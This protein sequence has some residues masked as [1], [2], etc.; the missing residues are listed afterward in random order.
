MSTWTSNSKSLPALALALLIAF[1]PALAEAKMGGGASSGSRGSRTSTPPAA[2]TT[3]PRP[4]APMERSVAPQPAP[5]PQ[6]SPAAPQRPAA[7]PAASPLGG[8]FGRGLL[9]GLAGGLLGAG[10]FGL[11][12]GNGL[13]GG[14]GGLASIIGLLVQIAII[15]LLARLAFQWFANRRLAGAMGGAGGGSRPGAF[16]FT[17]GG[18]GFGSGTAPRHP[19]SE[20]LNLR[21]EDF[22]AFERVLGDAQAAYSQEDIGRLHDLAMPEMVSY[23]SDDIRANAREGVINRISEVKLLQGDLSEAWREGSDEY[24]TVAMR[25]SLIDLFIDR[26]TGKIVSGDAAQPTQSTEVWTFRRPA[27]EAPQA[28]KLSAIQ[29]AA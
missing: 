5:Q 27:G 16:A 21:P 3:A 12:S 17:G 23:F 2:T 24:A 28:W 22:S 20:P 14:L 7:A 13:M 26:A 29:Q 6:P 15:A 9:G 8:S 18:T 11:L 25:F 1:A 19:T 10:L 4:A